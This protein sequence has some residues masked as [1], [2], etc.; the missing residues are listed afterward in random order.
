MC[1]VYIKCST[2]H[3]N[4]VRQ[5]QNWFR[6]P[7]NWFWFCKICSGFTNGDVDTCFLSVFNEIYILLFYESSSS[8]V[9]QHFVYNLKALLETQT[10]SSD[11]SS[12]LLHFTPT[13]PAHLLLAKVV[14]QS[15]NLWSK[16][17]SW[18]IEKTTMYVP[19]TIILFMSFRCCFFVNW[20]LSVHCPS[21]GGVGHL[22]NWTCCLLLQAMKNSAD[23]HVAC[24]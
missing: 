22:G 20:L 14:D 19:G 2:R 12:I 4:V 13:I 1:V 16:M 6:L 15:W 21:Q 9:S 23:Q 24:Q 18:E 8:K 11:I 3:Q 5:L 7:Q 17:V 10:F